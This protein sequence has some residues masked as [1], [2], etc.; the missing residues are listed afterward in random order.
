MKHFCRAYLSI[1]FND[2]NLVFGCKNQL[3]EKETIFKGTATILVDET[4]EPVWKM[5]LPFSEPI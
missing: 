2:F 5:R 1:G 3:R 4:L